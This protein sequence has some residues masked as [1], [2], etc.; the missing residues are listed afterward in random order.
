MTFAQLGDFLQAFGQFRELAALP[1][2]LDSPELIVCR[3]TGPYEV[4]MVGVRKPVRAGTGCGDHGS[5]LEQ[6]HRLVRTGEGQQVCDR[7]HSLRIGD[8]VPAAVEDAEMR[9]LFCCDARE[10]RGA[11]RA[12][13][14]DLEVWRARPAQ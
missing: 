10:K 1:E 5:F 6:E 9:A 4:G 11:V 13:A 2:P 3:P 8:D 12:R 14:S 7:L